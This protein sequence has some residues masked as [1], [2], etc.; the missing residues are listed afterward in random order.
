MKSKM[1]TVL[2]II[3]LLLVGCRGNLSAQPTVTPMTVTG[4]YMGVLINKDTGQPFENTTQLTLMFSE[5]EGVSKIP[6][7]IIIPIKQTNDVGGK[8]ILEVT[9]PEGISSVFSFVSTVGCGSSD[10]FNMT[11]LGKLE[12][13]QV[14]DVGEIQMSCK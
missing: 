11:K 2:I 5:D 4:K 12:I 1:Y 14:V 10:I 8:F 9:F 7:D 6:E 3:S 13:G